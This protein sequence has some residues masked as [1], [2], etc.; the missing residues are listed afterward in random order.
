MTIQRLRLC[1][2]VVA[3]GLMAGCSQ[4]GKMSDISRIT[5]TIDSGTILPELQWHEA[6]TIT[7]QG[8]TLTRSGKSND[9]QV[10]AGSWEVVADAQGIKALFDQLAGVDGSTIQ[11]VEPQDAPDGGETQTYTIAYGRDKELSLV[12]DPGTTYTNGELLVDPIK[13]F[14]QALDISEEAIN[15]YLVR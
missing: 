9:S 12:L 1:F 11:R 5:Y 7:E 10:N 4:A 6:I 15:R 14:I 13:D 2:L 8:V 3:C